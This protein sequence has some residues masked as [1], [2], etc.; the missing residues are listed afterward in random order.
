MKQ[1]VVKDIPLQEQKDLAD[2]YYERSA[3]TRIVLEDIGEGGSIPRDTKIK[4]VTVDM[5]MS[6]AVT[7]RTLKKRNMIRHALEIERPM[8]KEKID[9][10]LSDIF[11][12][13]DPVLRQVDYIRRWG[14]RAAQ[15]VVDHRVFIGMPAEAALESWGIPA[16]KNVRDIGNKVNEQW[17]YPFGKRSKYIYMIDGKVSKWEE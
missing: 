8:S 13:K 1:V 17:V 3:W 9:E 15:A 7:V 5:H 12:F 10:R 2:E 4:I 11:W 6:G 16:K 14:K